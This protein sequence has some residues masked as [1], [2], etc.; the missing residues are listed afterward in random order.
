MLEHSERRAYLT[1]ALSDH[2]RLDAKLRELRRAIESARHEA[3]DPGERID[4]LLQQVRNELQWHFDCEQEG[5]CLDE[6]VARLPRLSLEADR[7]QAEHEELLEQ[8]DQLIDEADESPHSHDRFLER[9]DAFYRQFHEHEQAEDQLLREGFSLADNGE[10][11]I[12]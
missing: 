12:H 11:L 2:R 6:V 9:L 5:G 8:L 1:Q 3:A 7:I 4:E 10:D